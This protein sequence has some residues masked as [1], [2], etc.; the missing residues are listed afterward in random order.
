MGERRYTDQ[1]V[2]R[3]LQRAAD[4]DRDTGG[5]GVARGLSLAELREIASEA[6]ID[7]AA[8]TRAAG[9]LRTAPVSRLGSTLLGPS[10]VVRR[11]AA[12]PARLGADA[13]GRLVDVVDA[14]VPAQGTVGEALGS[15]RWTSANRFLSRQVV[16]QPGEGETVVR[17]EERFTDRLRGVLH[18]L[19]A[20]YGGGLALIAATEAVAA[21]PWGAA[22]IAAGG[23]LAGL[24]LGRALWSAVRR[25]S[26]RRVGR[27][28]ER[29]EVEASDLARVE[30]D[31]G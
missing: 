3:L 4:L 15:V 25:R 24:G 6:G 13:L 16:I 20:A 22:A 8:V 21:G 29:L 19:P 28:A 23:A 14:E 9:E 27:L 10:P 26:S 12:V 30:S 11:T 2:T 5:T 31:R 1:E 7:P 18:G 17:V